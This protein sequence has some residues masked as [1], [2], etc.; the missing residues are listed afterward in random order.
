MKRNLTEFQKTDGEPYKQIFSQSLSSIRLLN[1]VS[2]Y[3]YVKE[4][5]SASVRGSFYEERNTYKHSEYVTAYVFAK[6]FRKAIDGTDM[7][8]A[9][10][11]RTVGSA[12]YDVL[13]QNL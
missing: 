7:I 1:A 5:V 2:V 4:Q 11:L 6:Q 10:T 13:R 12:P 3:R 9:Q 8:Q